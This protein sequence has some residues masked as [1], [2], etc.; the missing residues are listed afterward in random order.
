MRERE[1]E[2]QRETETETERD[3]ERVVERE[4]HCFKLLRSITAISSN[5]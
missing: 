4:V 1:R 3:K 2:R 5:E